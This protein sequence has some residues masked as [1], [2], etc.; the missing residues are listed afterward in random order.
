MLKV[1]STPHLEN[2]AAWVMALELRDIFV[3][4]PA[5][6]VRRYGLHK[7]DFNLVITDTAEAMSR[8]KTLNRFSVGGS[9]RDVM[10][11]L[12]ICGWSLNKVL[13]VCASFDCEPTKHVRLRD[14][15]KLWGYQRDARLEFCPFAAQRVNPLQELPK[16]WTIPHVVR[17]LARDTD[18]VVKT[19]WELTDDY[20]SD[21]DRNFGRNSAPE[22][23]ALLRELVECGR[24]WRIHNGHD[25]LSIH[26]GGRSYAIELPDRLIAA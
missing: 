5:A 6:H 17:L 23:L 8:G 3:A 2:R 26:Y 4:Q 18:A 25:G 14:Q 24:D 20:K 19:Q 9:E 11:F 10:D 13:E 22:R 7:D 21:A 1:I 12:A 15:L 16:K